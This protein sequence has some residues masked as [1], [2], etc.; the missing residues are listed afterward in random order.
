MA[1]PPGPA[2][3]AEAGLLSLL[4][5]PLLALASD[6]LRRPRRWLA[7]AGAVTLAAVLALPLLE[8]RTDGAALEL[9][10]DPVVRASRDDQVRFGDADPVIVLVQSRPGGPAVAS[11]QGLAVVAGLHDR[12]RE[13][14][15][16]RASG[17]RS[18]ASVPDLRVGE[19]T[20]SADPFLA[21][22]PQ[23]PRELAPWLRRLRA[24]SATDALL[25]SADGTAAALYLPAA[26]GADRGRLVAAVSRHLEAEPP[27]DFDWTPTGPLVA[28]SLL[29]AAVLEDLARLVPAMAV[30]LGLVLAFVLRAP[31]ALL[32]VMAEVGL[33]LAWTFG[34]LAASGRPLTLVTTSLPVVL[35][36]MAITDE[37]HVLERLQR[38]LAD[39]L[40][41]GEE[42]RGAVAASYAAALQQLARPLV[43]TTLTTCV[44]LLSFTLSGLPAL[45]TFGAAGAFGVAL[46]LLATF[47]VIPALA[48]VLPPRSRPRSS[49]P[50]AC[51]ASAAP[52]RSGRR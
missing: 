22:I 5:N 21:A 3:A 43:A 6:A 28:E 14:P 17:V 8:I 18:V 30:V 40:A 15:G 24:Q 1:P 27:A 13:V 33:V 36:A 12:L 50:A 52:R 38:L 16:V 37:V 44:G 48:A 26:E 2:P 34:G 39:A 19:D 4:C 41:R 46:A 23:D 9:P 20:L 10:D 42:P 25:L 7:G 45:R 35:L 11:A 29:G 32:L 51:C 49:R 47:T 31:G